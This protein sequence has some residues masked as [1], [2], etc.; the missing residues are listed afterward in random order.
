MRISFNIL[1]SRS[2][3][4]NKSGL[5]DDQ[6]IMMRVLNNNNNNVTHCEEILVMI[7]QIHY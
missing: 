5:N 6:G 3:S 2:L 4:S 7:A 1:R